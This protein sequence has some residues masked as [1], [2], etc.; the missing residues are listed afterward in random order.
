MADD[1]QKRVENAARGTTPQT[2]PDER[3]RYLGSLRERVLVRMD[4]EEANNTHYQK[5][6]LAHMADYSKYTVLI[7]AKMQNTV[8]LNQVMKKCCQDG[9]KFT[10]ISN[11]TAKTGLHDSAI[12]VVAKTAINKARIEISQVY[13][14]DFPKE[15]LPSP[16]KHNFW[17]N[18]FHG[19]DK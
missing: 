16:K 18:L 4:N 9:V 19:A 8:F 10:L 6:F 3:R 2:R 17:S 7:N 1:L 15:K 11:E 12:L 5:I 14:P 13:P